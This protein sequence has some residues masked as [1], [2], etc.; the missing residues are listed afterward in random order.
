MLSGCPGRPDTL[1]VHHARCASRDGQTR[2]RWAIPEGWRFEHSAD[3][4]A[5][6]PGASSRTSSFTLIVMFAPR[7][8]GRVD[9]QLRAPEGAAAWLR[10]TLE[11]GARTVATD[12]AVVAGAERP[13]WRVVGRISPKHPEREVA[14]VHLPEAH[15]HVLILAQHPHEARAQ[16]TPSLLAL[17]KTLQITTRDQAARTA[18]G[19]APAAGPQ[20]AAP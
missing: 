19:S 10:G 6:S 16:I 5:T 9:R 13:L 15:H 4:C 20:P 2:A 8:G 11:A 1:L 12:R 18:P 17:L 7:D 3:A 14:L